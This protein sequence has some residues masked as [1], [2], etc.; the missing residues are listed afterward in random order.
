FALVS[1]LAGHDPRGEEVGFGLLVGEIEHHRVSDPRHRKPDPVLVE[2]LAVSRRAGPDEQHVRA[3]L[4]D[5]A[6]ALQSIRVVHA[7]LPLPNGILPATPRTEKPERRIDSAAPPSAKAPD[8]DRYATSRAVPADP[9]PTRRLGA[10]PRGRDGVHLRWR[11]R[12]EALRGSAAASE[13]PFGLRTGG[14]REARPP[15]LRRPGEPILR[16]LLRHVPR[17]GWH[18]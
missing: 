10:G 2:R 6:E 16:P 12:T 5:A 14:A 4:D 9:N 1:E 7:D 15:D 8:R 13:G 3:L 11:R 17:G 18:P